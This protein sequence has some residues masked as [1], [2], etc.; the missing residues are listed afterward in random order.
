M[1][2]AIV[3]VEVLSSHRIELTNSQEEVKP[4]YGVVTKPNKEIFVNVS[5]M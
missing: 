4:V 1:E 5:R 3:A 2:M